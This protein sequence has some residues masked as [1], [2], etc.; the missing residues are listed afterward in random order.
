MYFGGVGAALQHE[1]GTL[2]AAGDARREARRG[3]EMATIDGRISP[4]GDKDRFDTRLDGGLLYAIWVTGRGGNPLEDASLK[5]SRGGTV[6]A[7]D[8]GAG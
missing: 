4:A 2:Q 5:V 3:D 8:D 7:R 1:D 6:V